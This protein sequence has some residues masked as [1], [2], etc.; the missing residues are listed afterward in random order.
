MEQIDGV[1]VVDA[2]GGT[3]TVSEGGEVKPLTFD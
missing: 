2:E 3:Y 1:L